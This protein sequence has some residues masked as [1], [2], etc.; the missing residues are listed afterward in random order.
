MQRLRITPS[1]CSNTNFHRR[2]HWECIKWKLSYKKSFVK[3][4]TN[5]GLCLFNVGVCVF[6]FVFVAKLEMEVT[7]EAQYSNS[8]FWEVIVVSYVPFHST[9]DYVCLLNLELPHM[10]LY[11]SEWKRVC[12]VYVCDVPSVH[13]DNPRSHITP[14]GIWIESMCK[15]WFGIGIFWT[16]I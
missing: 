13:L 12:N 5:N 6:V 14:R 4:S 8:V 16:W 2:S 11:H 10:L 7:Q 3:L 15:K 9:I 1:F